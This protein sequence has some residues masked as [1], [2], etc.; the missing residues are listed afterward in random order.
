[1]TRIDTPFVGGASS[2]KRREAPD[3]ELALPY[4]TGEEAAPP[5]PQA[6]PAPSAEEPE[7]AWES[8][9]DDTLTEAPSPEEELQAPGPVAE[10]PSMPAEAAMEPEPEV[11][12]PI[13]FVEA[14]EPAVDVGAALA[15]KP[16]SAVEPGFEAG[17]VSEPTTIAPEDVASAMVEPSEEEGED[18]D[19]T[20]FPDFLFG[21]EATDEAKN[22][23]SAT[24]AAGEA[25]SDFSLFADSE[26]AEEDDLTGVVDE[27]SQGAH[28]D[29]IRALKKSLKDEQADNIVS[30]A[31]AAG[32]LAARDEEQ[33]DR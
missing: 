4:S 21:D 32:Y 23:G 25:V 1:M 27:L 33:Q 26:P 11:A 15:T 16:E 20:G 2:P 30:R 31:F 29:R 7:D 6:T 3:S 14:D 12:S 24:E 5:A 28:A 17:S 18:E 9:L 19:D 8:A 13:D 10:D 22:M